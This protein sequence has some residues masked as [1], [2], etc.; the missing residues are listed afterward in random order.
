MHGRK[1]I[2]EGRRVDGKGDERGRRGGETRGEESICRGRR[3]EGG[4]GGVEGEEENGGKGKG[5]EM[6]CERRRGW[7]VRVG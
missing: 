4:R 2:G 5:G 1:E 7:S 3:W 6:C